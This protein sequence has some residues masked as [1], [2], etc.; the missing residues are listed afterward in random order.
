MEYG[1]VVL[2]S[3]YIERNWQV[4]HCLLPLGFFS[5]EGGEL[6]QIMHL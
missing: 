5:M 2:D 3:S 4:F 6:L 1:F